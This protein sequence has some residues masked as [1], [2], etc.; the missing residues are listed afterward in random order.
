MIITGIEVQTPDGIKLCKAAILIATLD[1]PARALVCNMKMYNG[2]YSCP[3]CMDPG[4]N[5]IGASSGVRYWPIHS[6]GQM[7][8]ISD[9]RS[10]YKDATEDGAPVRLSLH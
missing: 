7:R 3:T 2:K 9:V 8:S 5:T 6:P 4:D 10:A 1:L